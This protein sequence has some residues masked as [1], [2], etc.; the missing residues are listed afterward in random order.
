MNTTDRVRTVTIQRHAKTR[1][2][3]EQQQLRQ[4]LDEEAEIYQALQLGTKDYFHKNGFRHA[5]L[6]LSGGIDSAL[7]LAIA[8][9]ALWSHFPIS[10]HDAV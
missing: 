6:G 2:A 8:V 9:D 3:I 7:S 1:P 10:R 5:V 4:P